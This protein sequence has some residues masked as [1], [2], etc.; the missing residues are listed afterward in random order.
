METH[1][2]LLSQG[3]NQ[4]NIT[5]PYVDSYS[6]IYIFTGIIAAVFVFSMV[7]ALLFFK[8]AVDASQKLHNSMFT[9]IL[10]APIGFFDT[11]PV[12]QLVHGSVVILYA[13]GP[14]HTPSA[15]HFVW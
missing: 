8:V 1:Q 10:R 9:R 4:T 6:N 11:N 14:P 15:H 13:S 7:R 5:I 3:F 2:S 12:G